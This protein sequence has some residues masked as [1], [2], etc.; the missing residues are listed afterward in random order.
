[1]TTEQIIR[2]WVEDNY[3]KAEANCP[4]WDIKSLAKYLEKELRI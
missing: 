3:G 2:K 1:M 4:S